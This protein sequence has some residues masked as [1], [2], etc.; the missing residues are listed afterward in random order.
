MSAPAPERSIEL[1][2]GGMTCASCA[3]RI[4]KKLNRMDGVSAS[5]NYATEKAKVSYPESVTPDEL[6]AKVV[7]TGYTAAVHH[8][9]PARSEAA[10]TDSA[11]SAADLLRHKLLV[12]LAL[13]VPVVAM[14]MVPA[15]QFTNWQWLSLTLTAPVVFWS[16]SQFHRAA[17]VNAKHGAATMDTLISLGTLAAFGWSVYALFW[18]TAGL[19]GMKHPFSLAI[20]RG[21]SSSAL[22][23]EVAAT[24][25]TA[26]LAGRY[27]EVRSKEKAGSALRAL[28]E[29][30]AKDVAV[31]RGGVETRV[32]IGE[33]RVG[34]E[35]LVRPGEKVATDGVVVNGSSALDM[36]MLT[37]ESVPVEAGPGDQVVGATVNAGGLLTVRA[38]RIGAD[39]QL[40]QMAALVEDAQN[41]KAPV[42]RLADRVAGVF[43]P[44]VIAIAVAA[45]GFWLGTGA[46]VATAFGAA[47]A[48]LIIACPC[49]LGLATPTALLVG[50]GRGA[51]LGI[52]IKGPQVLE[53]TRRIDTVVLDKTGTVTTGKMTLAEAIP[54]DGVT[55]DEVLSVAAAVEHGSEH[56]VAKAV[57]AGAAERG[58]DTERVEQF[59]SHGGKGVQGLVGE[60]A[61]VIGRTELL[62]DWSIVLPE[63][64]AD[65]KFRAE[66]AGK[67]AIVVAWDGAARGVLVIAD[68]VKATSAQAIS[69]MK[70]LGLT[71]VLL[72]GDNAATARTVADQVGI[73][74]VIAEVLPSDKLD[75]V[76]QLQDRGKVVAMVGDGVNDAA[77]L[78]QAD[79]GL[80]MGTGT[81]VAIQAADLTLVRDDLR[82][83]PTSIKLSRATLRTI[84]GNLFWAFGYNVAAIPLAAAGLLNPMLAGAAMAL[85]S[86][87][88]VSN[89]LRLRRFR[90]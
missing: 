42:Q 59:V 15:L 72:T 69:E 55:A 21:D 54:A 46:A 19:P 35:F 67:T 26:I 18:G 74:E 49:A 17:W 28:L 52:L 87:F 43:V 66:Q 31:L 6:I 23:F 7:D 85:S 2:I 16:G 60:R 1:D 73:D 9:A 82:A 5:V 84:K 75:V 20:E 10:E 25:I 29:L 41:G 32:P 14:G 71:P 81:D 40:A 37:G 89:S 57:V 61:V 64:L 63:S 80:A 36:S 8:T 58:L 78:A 44:I 3:A 62:A 70:A 86:V 83:V 27:F 47:V 77:A 33:L 88:V 45:L 34:E 65:A 48:V 11:P 90:G 68:A 13:A 79:L 53:S 51:Q 22:Y 30:G 12:T 4:E 39:T 24:L 56:P 50:T 76:K 38:T